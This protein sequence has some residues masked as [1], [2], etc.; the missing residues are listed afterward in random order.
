MLIIWFY[1]VLHV[2]VAYTPDTP[3]NPDNLNTVDNPNTLNDPINPINP[4]V[5]R[6]ALTGMPTGPAT[7]SAAAVIGLPATLHVR[8]LDHLLIVLESRI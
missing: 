3:N 4:V 8:R 5:P 6:L 1:I 7:D 2:C